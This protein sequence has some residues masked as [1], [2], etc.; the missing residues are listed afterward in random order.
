[1]ES[2]RARPEGEIATDVQSR[3]QAEFHGAAV[4][5]AE[6]RVLAGEIGGFGREADTARQA[7]PLKRIVM[8]PKTSAFFM[9]MASLL[10]WDR[11]QGHVAFPTL[12]ADRRHRK[13]IGHGRLQI[14]AEWRGR[15]DRKP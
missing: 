1:V 6:V 12:A 9:V 14:P 11:D 13:L 5:V 15:R 8:T 7:R 4:D 10:S 3:L 2:V